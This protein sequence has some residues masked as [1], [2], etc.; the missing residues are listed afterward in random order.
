MSWI[1]L[2]EDWRRIVDGFHRA[3]LAIIENRWTLF[4]RMANQVF[5]D[6]HDSHAGCAKILLSAGKDDAVLQCYAWAVRSIWDQKK[7]RIP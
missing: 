4:L 1:A 2:P 6:D 7:G 3:L 5:A